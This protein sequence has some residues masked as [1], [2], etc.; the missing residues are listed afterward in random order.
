MS[1]AAGIWEQ[2]VT[3]P[4]QS[5]PTIIRSYLPTGTLIYNLSTTTAVW[6]SNN[7]GVAIGQGIRIGPLGSATWVYEGGA[8]YGVSDDP[9]V[10]VALNLSSNF[11]NLTNPVDVG[12]AVANALNKTKL[13]LVQTLA[14]G[15]GNTVPIDISPYSTIVIVASPNGAGQ[16][17]LTWTQTDD[18]GNVDVDTDVILTN[19]AYNST[20]TWRIAVVGSRLVLNNT[21][22]IATD[23]F[24]VGTARPMANG[25]RVSHASASAGGLSMIINING[26]GTFV[27]TPPI[28]Q[29]L[30]GQ[31]W[32][33]ASM[34]GTTTAVCYIACHVDLTAPAVEFVVVDRGEFV[35]DTGNKVANKLIALPS[36]DYRF[37]AVVTNFTAAFTITIEVAACKP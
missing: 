10:S 4:A 25:Q 20:R 26:N 1:V 17:N 22:G 6:V 37:E 21:L 23:V 28:G 5:N 24:V 35:V 36:Q 18:S 2:S 32:F 30:E 3:L 9:T 12:L 15:S 33:R 31:C 14:A 34:G 7:A 27:F 11:E 13:L 16:V 19:S 8:A 29:T